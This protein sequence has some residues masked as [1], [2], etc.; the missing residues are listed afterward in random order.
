[1]IGSKIGRRYADRDRLCARRAADLKRDG[2]PD[3]A[4]EGVDRAEWTAVGQHD[5]IADQNASL[6]RRRALDCA[7]HENAALAVSLGE[8]PDPRIGDLAFR[9]HPV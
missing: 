8:C 2:D 6:M 4:A 7:S 1:M 3:L 9:E 5:L